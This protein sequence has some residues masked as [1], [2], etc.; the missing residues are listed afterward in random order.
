MTAKR[1]LLLFAHPAFERSRAEPAFRDPPP[2]PPCPPVEPE[3]PPLCDPCPPVCPPAAA[4]PVV[5]A[6]SAAQPVGAGLPQDRLVLTPKRMVAPV[7]T[8]VTITA[9]PAV[10]FL[11]DIFG[12][13][14]PTGV[15]V[16]EDF[17]VGVCVQTLISGTIDMQVSFEPVGT[18]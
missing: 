16:I 9:V 13:C 17:L 12:N 14:E 8:E 18:D 2:V 3:C 4:V 5:P 7:G 1:V 10:G 6:P 11:F 15:E